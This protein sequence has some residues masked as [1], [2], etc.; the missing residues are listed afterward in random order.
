MVGISHV[1]GD[2]PDDLKGDMLITGK[3][4]ELLVLLTQRE[5]AQPGI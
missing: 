2:A 4:V 5:L 1:L 3:Q